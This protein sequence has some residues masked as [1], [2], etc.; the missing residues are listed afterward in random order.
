MC[1]NRRHVGQIVDVKKLTSKL[2][3]PAY[4]ILAEHHLVVVPSVL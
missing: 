3:A 1:V 4:P 2:Y